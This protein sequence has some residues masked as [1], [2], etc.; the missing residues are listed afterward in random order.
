MSL[1]LLS[2]PSHASAQVEADPRALELGELR[3]SLNAERSEAGIVLAGGG[4]ASLFGGAFLAGA[5]YG[6]PGV[7]AFGLGTGT[8]GLVNSLLSFVWL[9]AAA[10]GRREILGTRNL[11]GDSLRARQEELDG[12]RDSALLFAINT[13][14]DVLYVVAGVALF[15]VADALD[16]PAD[17]ASLRGYSVAQMSQGG[18]LFA[19]DLVEWIAS[20]QRA[21]RVARTADA[22]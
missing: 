21:D 2:L 12:Q 3:L 20:N 6:D 7:V 11:Q 17:R 5:G 22:R 13:L 18:L 14:L 16:A 10:R 8:W 4:L 19:F 9:D 15:F 1:A